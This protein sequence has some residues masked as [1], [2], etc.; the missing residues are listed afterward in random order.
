MEGDDVGG[1]VL[2][3]GAVVEGLLK[4]DPEVERTD[5]GSLL[6][7]CNKEDCPAADVVLV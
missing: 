1:A 3:E 6:L 2:V 4:V 5:E 7:P